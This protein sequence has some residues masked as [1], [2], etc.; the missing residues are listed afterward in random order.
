ME[1][2]LVRGGEGLRISIR[3]PPF[4]SDGT[5]ILLTI[6]RFSLIFIIMDIAIDTAFIIVTS[7]TPKSAS[8]FFLS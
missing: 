7:R 5:R 8:A 3:V 6:K 4:S 2:L 1:I